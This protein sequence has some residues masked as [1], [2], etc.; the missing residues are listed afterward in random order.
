LEAEQKLVSVVAIRFLSGPLAEKTIYI[1]KPVTV[2][3]RDTQNDI[4]VF[5]SRVSRRHVCI[6]RLNGSWA[7]ENLSQ[8][9]YVAVNQQ[10]IQHEV[11]QHNA[12]V[13]LGENISF[14][15]LIQEP[16]PQPSPSKPLD[17]LYRLP[18]NVLS[19]ASP[20][21]TVVASRSE[22]GMPS[23]TV[24]SNVHSDQQVHI[25]N[26]QVLNIGRDPGNDIVIAEPM[27]SAWH[28]Q[29]VRDGN[30]LFLVHPHPSRGKTLNGLWYQGQRIRGDQQFRKQLVRGDIFRIGDEYGTL[31]T[32]TY[33]DG[34]GI[35]LETLPETKP[36]PLTGTR[37]MIGRTP[38]NTVV[39]NHPQ[40][41]AHHAVLE[42]VEGGYRVIDTN[43]T[44]HVYVSGQRITNQLL[45]TG[46]EIRI[47]PYR[48]IYTGTEL[49]QSGSQ[50]FLPNGIIRMGFT[51]CSPVGR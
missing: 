3:G 21:G 5:D 51:P 26:K 19:D 34:A 1:Q 36:I 15:F 28:A 50:A 11:L 24:S 14:I 30:N 47:G 4:V 18:S 29:I 45:R 25:L 46:D 43:S 9:S 35:P 10:R 37:L 39:L 2:I 7:I 6:R 41:S 27:V 38:D 49:R 23:L 8:T 42:K 32:L 31:V 48:L 17:P 33:D 44:N 16:V 20:S 13:S 40:V 22:I 12:L